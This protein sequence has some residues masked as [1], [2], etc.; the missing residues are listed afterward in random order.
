[1][2]VKRRDAQ[3]VS[4]RVCYFGLGFQARG[5]K[6][7]LGFWHNHG[8]EQKFWAAVLGDLRR[9]GVC[10]ALYLVGPQAQLL[11]AGSQH[12]PLSIVLPHA[13]DIL[14]R[15]LELATTKNRGAIASALRAVLC[16]ASIADAH[17][18]MDEFE[19]GTLG[20]KYP[21]IPPIWRNQWQALESFYSLPSEVRRVLAS[22]HAADAIRRGYRRASRGQVHASSPEGAAILIYLAVRDAMRRWKRPQREW[23]AAKLRLAMTFPE[24]FITY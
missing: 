13:G 5:P 22:T 10:D 6:E 3:G 2:L 7:V 17:C 20:E 9:R 16:A 8:D 12:L 23:H 4:S 24:R 19:R 1:M 18:V 14:R 15:S 21:A 11:E